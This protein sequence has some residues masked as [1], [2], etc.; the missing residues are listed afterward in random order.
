MTFVRSKRL[1]IVCVGTLL[2]ILAACVTP[3]QTAV[4]DSACLTFKVI[5]FD[6][7]NDTLETIAQVKEHNAAWRALCPA[8]K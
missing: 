1:G 5:Q 7:L 3:T 2:L 8:Q 6:R 4:P